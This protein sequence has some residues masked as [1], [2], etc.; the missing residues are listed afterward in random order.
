MKKLFAFAAGLLLSATSLFAE[1]G[2]FSGY[3]PENWTADV[4]A[5]FRYTRHYYSNWAE[6]GTNSSNWLVRYD[7]DVKGHWKYVDWRNVV[8]L[9]WGTNY[10]K[11]VGNRKA[12]DKIFIETTLDYN[13]FKVIKPYMGARFE[14][15][16][17]KGY[18]YDDEDVKTPISCFFDPAYITQF[19]GI[20][21]VPNDMFS[22]RL[23]FANRMTISD[24]YGFADDPDTKKIESFKDE[25]GLESITEFKY[26]LSDIV[27]FKTR[28]WAFVNFEGI[29]DIDG[30]WENKLSVALTPFIEVEIGVELFYDNDLD[31]DMQYRDS[32]LFGLTWRW[33]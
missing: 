30:R 15:Q 13:L 3:L 9:A 21:Y 11:G 26:A 20:A 5:S 23:A 12:E 1:N 2:M 24:G 27:S 33:F 17:T 8:N 10:T 6:D 28:L 31:E 7:A 32:M 19:A 18:K 16:F 14:S 29:D 4:V 25:P 22:Q